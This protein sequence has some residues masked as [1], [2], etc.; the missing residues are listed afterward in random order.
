MSVK[1]QKVVNQ[2]S[3]VLHWLPC[4]HFSYDLCM[5]IRCF[6]WLW[7]KKASPKDHRV[8]SFFLSPTG[9][10]S[11]LVTHT[12]YGRLGACVLGPEASFSGARC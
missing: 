3:K 11:C 6:I 8:C 4:Y 7:V 9:F 1:V 5:K 10:F 2:R 12:W